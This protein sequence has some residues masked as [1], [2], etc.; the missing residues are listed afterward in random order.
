MTNFTLIA[1]KNRN[2]P[3]PFKSDFFENITSLLNTIIKLTLLVLLILWQESNC[4][5]NQYED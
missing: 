2:V 1:V 5:R 3:L 4:C